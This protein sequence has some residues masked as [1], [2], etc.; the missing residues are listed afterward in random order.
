M[1]QAA[2]LRTRSLRA[3]SRIPLVPQVGFSFSVFYYCFPCFVPPRPLAGCNGYLAVATGL[4]DPTPQWRV[5]GAAPAEGWGNL[6]AC[7]G[8]CLG[9]CFACSHNEI[10]RRGS[11]LVV[12]RGVTV[13][14]GCTQRLVGTPRN[15]N[16][17]VGGPSSPNSTPGG[18]PWSAL[19]PPFS[20]DPPRRRGGCRSWR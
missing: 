15:L 14:G 9:R 20:S 16:F 6:G 7:I 3:S 13:E 17:G 10:R 18:C 1:G 11:C 4:K 8:G 19:I 2:P 12:V 5:P